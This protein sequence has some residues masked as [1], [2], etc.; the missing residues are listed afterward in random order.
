M[1]LFD[2]TCEDACAINLPAKNRDDLLRAV[3]RQA[4][5]APSLQEVGEEVI[6]EALR[7]R[8]NEGSTGFGGGVAIPHARLPEI[9]EFTFF[10]VTTAKPIEFAA[11]DKKKV[12]VFF[13]ILGPPEG[14]REHV[15]ILAAISNVVCHS[16][17]VKEIQQAKTPA[18]VCESFLSKLKDD[19]PTQDQVKQKLLI[20]VLYEDDLFHDLLE[21]YI[22]E[23]ID[24][25][26]VLDSSGMGQYISN[27]PLFASF[28]GFMNESKNHS[29]TIL[30]MVPENRLNA[31]IT[32]IQ[33]ITGDLDKMQGAMIMALD[34]AFSKGTMQMM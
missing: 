32:G 25:A 28:I 23:G 29:R 26:T 16:N 1:Q 18:V 15:Q 24:G 17:V 33:D 14:A 10:I 13:V 27:I 4:M 21:Y 2:I 7:T 31:I 3:A 20:V 5:A 12:S 19:G 8:E 11:L 9:R 22:Q 30:A 34:V 6:F